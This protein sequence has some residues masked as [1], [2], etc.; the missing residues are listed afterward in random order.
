MISMRKKEFFNFLIFFED[1]RV[2]IWGRRSHLQRI[3]T[4]VEHILCEKIKAEGL[5]RK[6]EFEGLN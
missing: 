2:R 4:K 6:I 5:V 3:G 1:A